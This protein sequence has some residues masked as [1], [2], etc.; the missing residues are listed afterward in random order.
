M[1]VKGLGIWGMCKDEYVQTT[2]EKRGMDALMNVNDGLFDVL[3]CYYFVKRFGN[4]WE[5]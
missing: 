2:D 5:Y 1:I 3:L 4:I